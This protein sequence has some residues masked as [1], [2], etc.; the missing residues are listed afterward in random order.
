MA[1]L[2]TLSQNLS[3]YPFLKHN[4]RCVKNGAENQYYS[5]HQIGFT[6]I[7][8]ILVIVI[9]SIL[10]ATALPR[11]FSNQGFNER[12][13]F[14]DTLNAIRYAQKLAVATGCQT[15]FS[16][17]ENSYSVLREDTCGSGLFAGNLAAFH[18]ATG[19]AGY[20]GSQS[21]VTLTATQANTTFNAL[22]EAD[23]NNIIAIGDRQITVVAATGFGYDST[24]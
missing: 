14:D 5:R 19:A 20:T 7:E 9:L 24:P 16:V 13:L 21:G 15:R 3:R 17:N 1:L 22:G 4:K 11:F 10:S 6:L 23:M 18:P 2:N 8:L 12:A